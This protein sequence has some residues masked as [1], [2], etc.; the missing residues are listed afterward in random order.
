MGRYIQSQRNRC[1]L[2]ACLSSRSLDVPLNLTSSKIELRNLL[3]WYGTQLQKNMSYEWQHWQ[4]ILLQTQIV[5][6]MH[7]MATLLELLPMSPSKRTRA[8]STPGGVWPLLRSSNWPRQCWSAPPYAKA[9]PRMATLV[10]FHSQYQKKGTKLDWMSF[11]PR[12]G[13]NNKHC[14]MHLLWDKYI[15]L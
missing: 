2:W 9:W 10:E 5:G 15:M 4:A 13:T 3:R 7:K 6:I 8:T 11:I 12:R 14:P 1:H